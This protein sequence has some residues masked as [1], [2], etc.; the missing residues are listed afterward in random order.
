MD[1]LGF[2][3]SRIECTEMLSRERLNAKF[4]IAEVDYQTVWAAFFY[5]LSAE[6]GRMNGSRVPAVPLSLLISNWY[7]I[8]L[9]GSLAS[10]KDDSIYHCEAHMSHI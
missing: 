4:P 9:H 5:V 10:S 7:A 8:T 3:A 6:T 1:K 2:P